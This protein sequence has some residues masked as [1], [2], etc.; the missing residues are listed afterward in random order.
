MLYMQ[1]GHY[2]LLAFLVSPSP[3]D[4][5]APAATRRHSRQLAP[6]VSGKSQFSYVVDLRP[7]P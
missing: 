1:T 4:S 3:R 2:P 6:Q 5:V 7:I